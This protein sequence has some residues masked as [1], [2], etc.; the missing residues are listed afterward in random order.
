MVIML[1]LEEPPSRSQ[2]SIS[3]ARNLAQ[4]ILTDLQKDNIFLRE[5]ANR[6]QRGVSKYRPCYTKLR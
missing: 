4:N 1:A 2:R 3:A 5:G 6:C